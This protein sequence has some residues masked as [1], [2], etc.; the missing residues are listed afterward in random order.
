VQAGLRFL[1]DTTLG[2]GGQVHFNTDLRQISSETIIDTLASDRY[3]ASQNNRL[4]LVGILSGQNVTK[5]D[6]I[7]FA[8]WKQLYDASWKAPHVPGS[9]FNLLPYSIGDSAVCY[10]YEPKTIAPGGT[11]TIVIVLASEDE[12]GI[13]RSAP[14]SQ[15]R[16]GESNVV[17]SRPG[18][19]SG[20]QSRP[21]E[22]SGVPSRPG[23][24][25]SVPSDTKMAQ[26]MQ[27]DLVTL[28]IL[29]D[30][31]DQYAISGVVSNE[32][33]SA[34]ELRILRLKEK[35]GIP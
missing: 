19:S 28:Q 33:L 8:N 13:V 1:L 21:G 24:S 22:S 25:S 16:P 9:H 5:P 3:W 29:L 30:I 14:A 26:L 34:I 10:Y 31:L 7:H 23:E 35:Y 27:E 2:E 11:R 4:A 17:Q 20:V 15:S 6:F 12:N 18:E 32:E